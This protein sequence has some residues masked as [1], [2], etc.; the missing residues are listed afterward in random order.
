MND[1]PWGTVIIFSLFCV[2][3][4]MAVAEG[5]ARQR[6]M[7]QSIKEI[8]DSVQEVRDAVKAVSAKAKEEISGIKGRLEACP[9]CPT[10]DRRMAER[11]RSNS[12]W[13]LDSDF[14]KP[15]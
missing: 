12:D 7:Q 2:M 14:G 11:R 4:I 1:M 6:A 10:Q 8:H 3:G 9:A 15:Q 5:L 13:M